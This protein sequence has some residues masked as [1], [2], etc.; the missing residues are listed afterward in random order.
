MKP[1][2]KAKDA[3]RRT[4]AERAPKDTAPAPPKPE[5]APIHATPPRVL[6]KREVARAF[7]EVSMMLEVL[8]DNPFRIRAFY[9]AAR[10]IEDLSDDLNQLAESGE[11]IKVRGIGKSMV[12]NV[13]SLLTTGTFDEFE[14]LKAKVPPG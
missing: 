10:A 8:G 14:A 13:K 5:P 7:D 11:L 2:K 12:A 6:S 9:N 3:T 4:P 1:P